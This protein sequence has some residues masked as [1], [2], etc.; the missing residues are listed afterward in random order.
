MIISCSA[1]DELNG[2]AVN[3]SNISFSYSNSALFNL[4]PDI[5][6]ASFSKNPIA[7]YYLLC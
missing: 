1:I 6:L 4:D 7:Y 5:Q 2:K 3:P